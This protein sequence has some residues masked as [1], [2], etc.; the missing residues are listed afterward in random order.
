MDFCTHTYICLIQHQK[1]KNL[2]SL[3]LFAA[4]LIL[5]PLS[6]QTLPQEM[7]FSPDG[8]RLILGGNTADGLYDETLVRTIALQFNQP[9][10]WQLLQTNYQTSTDI[11]ATMTVDG[12]T[13][14]SVGV[15]FRGQT[16]FMQNFSQKK[17]FNISVDYGLEDQ[18]LM[19]YKTLNL[20]CGFDDQSS[21]REVLYNHVGRQ[22]STSLK[23]NFVV[24]TLN[25]QN[26]GPYANVQQ[27]NGDYFEQWFLSN[28]GNWWRAL[29]TGSGGP[30]G[31]G[32][33]FGTGYSTLNYLGTDTSGYQP[34]YTLKNANTPNPWQDLVTLCTKLNNLP[35]NQLEDSLIH[36]LD[37]D[38]ALWYLA[39]EIIFT[40]D[41]SYVNKGGM[42]YYIYFEPETGRIVPIEYD[43]NSCMRLNAV[44]WSPFY[45]ETDIKYPLMNRL[46]AVLGLRQRYLAHVRTI[47]QQYMDPAVVH[48]QIDAYASLIGPLVESDP[49]KIYSYAQ[50]Q[51][52]VQDVKN[53]IVNRRNFLLNHP[54]VN[55]A[56]LTIANAGF[57][58]P[59]PDA[60]EEVAV[61]A[62]V[63]GAMGIN[64]VMLYYG[65]GFVG[66]FQKTQM[67]DDGQHGDGAPGDGVFGVSIPG[68][69][70][71][72]YV[73]YYIEAI[74]N[75]TP[76]T[77]TYEPAG[78]E[79]DVYIYRVNP[80][81]AI[82]SDVVINELMADNETTAADPDGEYDDWIELYNNAAEP[83]DLSGY[84]LTDDASNL[85]KWQFPAGTVIAGEGY[86]IIWAD[87]DEEQ[88]GLHANFKLS[89]SGEDLILLNPGGNI[90]NQLV[91]SA[92]TVDMGYARKPN[93]T[94]GFVVQAPTF[95]G[96]N[97]SASGVVEVRP[98]K[99]MKIWPNPAREEVIV[100]LPEDGP[101]ELRI[102]DLWG[103][104][105]HTQFLT[106]SETVV[107]VR[108]LE[109][110]VYFLLVEGMRAERLVVQN[111]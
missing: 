42:D 25:G 34:Y 70:A 72:T 39:H 15:R 105:V 108:N 93:G 11:F 104:V 35:L 71:G 28:D 75:N 18:R 30:G 90:L 102:A 68:F 29:K 74:A 20:N 40:D 16:S 58:G 7:H 103:R 17:S 32:G 73:R 64:R 3:A 46:F 67:Y 94:G 50:F 109:A 57:A 21:I 78:A 83:F 92:Q 54:E 49:K 31:P 4:C 85:T 62:Q 61:T 63:S 107:S 10:Y 97:D 106:S 48:P 65:A 12:V 19:G 79:H 27:I 33:G 52:A 2:F 77:A 13:Y 53:F 45:K 88:E 6:A 91:F 41:D 81:S 76:K 44:S 82:D 37:V 22:Y 110:G 51:T 9:N 87:E 23:S 66:V 43:G 60:G 101:L 5:H 26:W 47:L 98:A 14:D 111:R 59:A 89:S 56:G 86:L 96:N 95:N 100:Q 24:L 55:A 84:F 1:M 69:P 36:Y 8:R 80:G 99:S 38:K